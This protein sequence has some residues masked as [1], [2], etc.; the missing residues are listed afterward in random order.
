MCVVPHLAQSLIDGTEA[1]VVVSQGRT[2]EVAS[3]TDRNPLH[4][5]GMLLMRNR[6]S[7]EL[8]GFMCESGHGKDI[9]S[10]SGNSL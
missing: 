8:L 3:V 5:N 2:L 6:K 4:G 9:F 10:G 7:N 1:D